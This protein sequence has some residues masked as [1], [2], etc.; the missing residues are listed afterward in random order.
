MQHPPI[1][2]VIPA[3]SGAPSHKWEKFHNNVFY[4]GGLPLH[5]SVGFH[6]WI[7]EDLRTVEQRYVNNDAGFKMYLLQNML[8]LHP[9]FGNGKTKANAE[10]LFQMYKFMVDPTQKF[11]F[12]KRGL[13]CLYLVEKTRSYYYETGSDEWGRHRVDFKFIRKAIDNETLPQKGRGMPTWMSG[14]MKVLY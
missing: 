13:Q 4:E 9:D 14:G 5:G 7:Q 10:R 1:H 8:T 6:F 3:I 12:I 11:F 2:S